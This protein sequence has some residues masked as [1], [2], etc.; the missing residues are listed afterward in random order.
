VA[1]R[2]LDDASERLA[3]VGRISRALY[4]PSGV[5]QDVRSFLTTLARDV[6][7]ASGRQDIRLTVAAPAGLTLDA[8]TS[9]PLALVVAEAVS[10]AIEH[11]LPDRAGRIEVVLAMEEAGMSLRIV[12]DGHGVA[13]E[14]D[15]AKSGSLGL[16]IA[17]AL[18][19]QL[20]GSFALEPGQPRGAIARL[21]LP[22]R[23]AC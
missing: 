8:N 23:T 19:G 22:L 7:D 3:L 13:P 9:I 16:R 12:D 6:L 14:V 21:D 11:G 18:A 5:G 1:R 15:A 2:A 4:D 20:G 10:N 17:N